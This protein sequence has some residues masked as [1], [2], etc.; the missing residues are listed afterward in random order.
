MLVE[1]MWARSFCL[2]ILLV[3]ATTLVGCDNPLDIFPENPPPEPTLSAVVLEPGTAV[4]SP[5]RT[6][7]FGA[8]GVMS[9]GT[10][11]YSVSITYSA[12]GGTLALERGGA[13]YTAGQVPGTYYVTAETPSGSDDT[14]GGVSVVT[15]TAP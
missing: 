13:L 9:N 5:G 10:R 6:Q 15:I 7:L 3:G 1:R 12:T 11:N 2:R 14:F 4:L 8:Y